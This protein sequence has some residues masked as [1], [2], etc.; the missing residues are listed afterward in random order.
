MLLVSLAGAVSAK[1]KCNNGW[2]WF[3][4]C[5]PPKPHTLRAPEIDP[6]SAMAALTFMAGG[7]AVLR[8]RRVKIK[9]T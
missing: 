6:T 5:D 7:L 8:G 1:D 2:S 9:K 4:D 3:A